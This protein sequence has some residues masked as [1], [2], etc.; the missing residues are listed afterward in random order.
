MKKLLKA[1]IGYV[2]GLV[3]LIGAS[4]LA[5]CGI[6]KLITLCFGFEFS[7]LMATGVWII[8]ILLK[9]VFGSSKGE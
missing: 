1:I 5:I 4:W 3:I 8:L 2:L 7:W 6:V 9:S